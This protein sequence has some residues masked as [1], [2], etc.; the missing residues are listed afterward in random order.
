MYELRGIGKEFAGPGEK[1][2]LFSHLDLA[3]AAGETVAVLGASGSGKSTLLHIL[4]TLDTPSW[5]EVRF[6]G[7][8]IAA[9][10][11][12][13]RARV[14]NAEMG[15]VFQFHHLLPEFDTV[16]NVAMPGIIAGTPRQEAFARA[17]EALELAGLTGR[18]H[19]SVNTLS[20]GER[21]RAAIARALFM[22]PKVILADEPTGNL[23]E[24]TGDHVGR[25]LVELNEKLGTTLVVVTHNR[26]LAGLMQR[27]LVLRS[28]ELHAS[29]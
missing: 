24:A 2:T 18:D 17:R 1:L 3:V 23:D 19:Q 20:G 22:R 12:A 29:A 11:A 4:G 27:R 25:T 14:R 6:R 28:G 10:G 13:E 16:E 26:D 15:F 7:R 8:N 9:M 5:G 21:Q